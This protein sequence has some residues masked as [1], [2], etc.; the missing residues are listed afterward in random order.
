M[1]EG[2]AFD[3]APLSLNTHFDAA[4]KMGPATHR[5]SDSDEVARFLPLGAEENLKMLASL[6]L[7]PASA[8]PN[9]GN[10]TGSNNSECEVPSVLHC[11]S[12]WKTD[13]TVLAFP[14]HTGSPTSA[15]LSSGE[16]GYFGN[17]H[18]PDVNPY[19][20][21]SAMAMQPGLNGASGMSMEVDHSPSRHGPQCTGLPQL[22]MCTDFSTAL[23]ARCPNCDFSW[24]VN[25][26]GH[27]LCYSP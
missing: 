5:K 16:S 7:L 22:Y 25:N 26:G 23:F 27:S 2:E 17:G 6:G 4:R 1:D 12:E 15:T 8:M 20:A 19:G 9:S 11:P 18:Y 24:E 3:D 10:G 21:Q 14:R 13:L